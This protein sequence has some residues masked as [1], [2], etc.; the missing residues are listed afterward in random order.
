MSYIPNCRPKFAKDAG[1][2]PYRKAEDIPADEINPYY[3]G[4]LN[5]DNAEFL[6]GFDWNTA[7]AV[8]KLF[9]NLDVYWR[10]FEHAGLNVDEIDF[11]VDGSIECPN[12]N[13]PDCGNSEESKWFSEYSEEELSKMSQSTKVMLLMKE[14]LNDYIEK[15][16]DILVTSMIDDMEDDEHAKAVANLKKS[17]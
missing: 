12:A 5:G 4:L 1:S 15:E 3:Y 16:R 10:E 13:L 14:I 8:N 17:I 6:K 7:N 11:T 2:T 9:D